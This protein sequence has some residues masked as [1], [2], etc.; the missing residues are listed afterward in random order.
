MLSRTRAFAAPVAQVCTSRVCP[1]AARFC[2]RCMLAVW[3]RCWAR[4]SCTSSYGDRLPVLLRSGRCL[5]LLAV[6]VLGNRGRGWVCAAVGAPH[7]ALWMWVFLRAGDYD[8]VVVGG[9]PGGYVAAIKAG[10]LG[11]KV[12]IGRGLLPRGRLDSCSL[13]AAVACECGACVYRLRAW[14][15]VVPWVARASTWAASHP[16]HC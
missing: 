11:M 7:A 13:C 6:R 10:Q 4:C 14:R 3:C 1:C 2:A 12:G 9:G 15:S 16:R 8:V 5:L